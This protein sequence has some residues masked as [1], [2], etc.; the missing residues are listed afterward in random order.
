MITWIILGTAVDLAAELAWQTRP[1]YRLA[2]LP[3]P[4]GQ[5]AGFTLVQ[6]TASGIHFTNWLAEQRS[7]TNQIFLNGSGVAAGDFDGDGRCDLY[8]CGLDSPNALYRNLGNFQFEDVTARAGVAC[9]DQASTGATFADVDGDG[10]L[11]LLVNG[12]GRGTRLFLNDGAGVFHE[13]TDQA[14]LRHSGGATSLTLADVDGDGWLDLYVVNYRNDTM[15]DLPEIRFSVATSN[16]VYQL[17]SVNDQP[18]QSPELLGR[19]TFDQGRNVLENGQA[20]ILFRNLGG[21][22]FTPVSWTNGAFLD[23]QGLPARVPFDWGLSAMFRD[24]NDDGAPDLYVCNDFQSPDRIWLNDGHGRFRAL[25]RLAIRQTSLFSMGVD[26]A[27]LDRDGYLDIFVADMLSRRHEQRQVQV[28]DPMAFA[29]A[30]SLAS[31]RPQFSRNTLFRNRGDGTYAEIAQLAGVDASDW[32]WCPVFLDVDL[33]GYEDLLITTGH[34]RDAQHADIAREL[35]EAKRQK[36]LTPL[37]ELQLR[38][39]FPR[40]LTP[41]V[42]FRNRGDWTFEEVG[43][44]WGFDARAI[45]HGLALADLDDDGDLDVVINCLN[46]GPLLYRNE[47]TRAR[48]AVRLRGRPPNTQGVGARIDVRTSGLPRQRSEIISGGRYL[49]GDQCLRTFAAGTPTNRMR[50]EITWRSGRH[51]LIADG[52]ADCVYEF[53]EPS[54]DSLS[55][56][57]RETQPSAEPRPSAFEDASSLLAHHHV[58]EPFDDFAR[59]P[60]LARRFSQLGPGISWIDFNGDGY[61]DLF[62]GTGRAGR[63]AVFRNDARGHFVRQK[64]KFL[65]TPAD[66]DLTTVLGWRSSPTDLSLLIGLS[67]YEGEPG[68]APALRQFSVTTG[69]ADENLLPSTSATGPLALGD[70]DGDGD[71]DLFIGG[72]INP[73]RYPEPARSALLRCDRGTLRFD[74]PASRVLTNL[75]LVT[76]AIF[77]DL[78]GDGTPELVLAVEWGALRIFRWRQGSLEAWNA[79]LQWTTAG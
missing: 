22:R 34:W 44:A 48:V 16:G 8:F 67:N 73:G 24:L 33:D 55:S 69:L 27:D 10:D 79:P 77:T 25:P 5:K 6:P 43:S 29:Q 3:G 37:E 75:G 19:Y 60:L 30:R 2:P 58:D 65:E 26:V 78:T 57:T 11:D 38:R 20:D 15:R 7:I 62:V 56:E 76:S 74:A 32:S 61:D 63:L 70:I 42:L 71:L 35:D 23:E 47:G 54:A 66:R 53:E 72:R 4:R 50:I 12:I 39:R 59:Q 28:M 45:S 51:S 68:L 46:A 49:S 41:N 13:A 21:G 40:L 1:G 18:V 36:R 31:D 52:P 14:G 17:L 9:G 64:A